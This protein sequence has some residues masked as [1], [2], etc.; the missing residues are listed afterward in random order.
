[1]AQQEQKIKKPDIWILALILSVALNGLAIGYLLAIKKEGVNPQPGAPMSSVQGTNVDSPR[2]IL[3]PLP[4]QRR[5]QAMQAALR[6]MRRDGH[7]NPRRQFREHI[8]AKRHIAEIIGSE[9]FDVR[10]LEQALAKA[11]TSR[12]ALAVQGDRLMVEIMKT[13]NAEE[14]KMV[15]EHMLKR[16]KRAKP[17]P[18]KPQNRQ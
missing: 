7:I 10:A 12:E 5:R 11:R 3:R 17:R 9:P 6:E 16:K 1:M 2:R 13:L 18:P 8:L 14:R 4:P 15:A